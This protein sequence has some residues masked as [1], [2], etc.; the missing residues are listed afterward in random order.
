MV[1]ASALPY[2]SWITTTPAAMLSAATTTASQKKLLPRD[3]TACA[4]PTTPP[5]SRSQPKSSIEVSVATPV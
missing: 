5:I 2:G 4:S 3:W 1:S